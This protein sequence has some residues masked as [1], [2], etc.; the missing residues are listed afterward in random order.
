M[1]DAAVHALDARVTR[2]EDQITDGFGRV[3]ALLRQEINDLKTEQI[4]DLRKANERL[5]DDQR[6]LWER[7]FEMERRETRR[8]GHQ[9]GA[10][11]VL[12]ALGHLFSAGIGGVIAWAASYFSGGSP[13]HHP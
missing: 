10:A 13:P 4:N 7:V 3:E 12:S 11:R 8:S 2:I 1:N 6:R 9:S 5:A